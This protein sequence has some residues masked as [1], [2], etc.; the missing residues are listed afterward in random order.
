MG[1]VNVTVRWLLAAAF[2]FWLWVQ[3]PWMIPAANNNEGLAAWVQAVGSLIGLGVAIWVPWRIHQRE[4]RAAAEP[5]LRKLNMLKNAFKLQRNAIDYFL[6]MEG[7]FSGDKMEQA[8]LPEVS[9]QA[10]KAIQI[11]LTGED[12][13]PAVLEACG[14]ELY[15]ARREVDW[16]IKTM[17]KHREMLNERVRGLQLY[18]NTKEVLQ[19]AYDEVGKVFREIDTAIKRAIEKIV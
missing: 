1:W 7:L 17:A 14:P 9:A 11:Y 5:R 4:L 13:L 6:A 18:P 10:Y 12:S 3:L 15:E 16:A 8:N 19:S 2:L